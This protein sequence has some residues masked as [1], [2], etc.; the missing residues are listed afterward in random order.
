MKWFTTA[1][2]LLFLFSNVQAHDW[3]WTKLSY[4]HYAEDEPI[5][6][7]L[8]QFASAINTP[9]FISDKVEGVV[10]G[11]FEK[12]SARKFIDRIGQI[13]SLLWY[14]DGQ[15]LYIYHTSEVETNLINLEGVSS[16]R[17]ISTLK[18]LD[19]LDHRFTLRAIAS[20]NIV[21]VSGPPRYTELVSEVASILLTKQINPTNNPDAFV[22]KVFKLKHAWADDRSV[23]ISGQQIL[24]P[25]VATSLQAILGRQTPTQT[26]TGAGSNTISKLKGQGLAKANL[27]Q[28]ANAQ[29]TEKNNESTDNLNPAGYVV[30]NERLNAVVVH[31]R[32]SMMPLYQQLIDSLDQPSS[33]I[34]IE[35]SIIDVNADRLDEIGVEWQLSG[36]QGGLTNTDFSQG[37][38]PDTGNEISLVLG[39][40]A[41]FSPLATNTQDIF[42][43]RIRALSEDG[44][45]SLLSQPSI[46]TLDNIEAVLD[47]STTFFVRLAGEREVDLFPVSVGSIVRVTP[48][49]VENESD[50]K[51]HLDI[52]IED[53]QQTDQSVDDIPS[54]NKSVINTEA[55][56]NNNGSL[57][58][59][60]YYFNHES[61]SVRKIP[62]LGSIPILGQLF[63]KNISQVQT[64]SRLFLI[65]PR[66]VSTN[67]PEIQYS[68][69]IESL[70]ERFQDSDIDFSESTD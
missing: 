18:T 62:L 50:Q 4:A 34:E 46:V 17:L 48:H 43:S 20:E 42:L 33:Q 69:R 67:R 52:N 7:F 2:F 55:V 41:A 47:H 19:V 27:P 25:G 66:I 57:L 59:G 9:V 56:V 11:N 16:K 40:G 24:M 58:L 31:D 70:L 10:N 45:A 65:S 51:I 44:D 37:V 64:R 21:M 14:F 63:R 3:R 28:S 1:I 39:D 30:A 49:I 12:T 54:I 13:H 6:E 36:N 29:A 35:V 5:R 15:V 60:G 22:V 38:L 61:S 53:G 68:H 23:A 8:L 32:Q 26:I